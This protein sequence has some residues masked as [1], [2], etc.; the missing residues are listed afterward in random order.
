MRS[1]SSAPISVLATRP[2]T[3]AQMEQLRGVSPRIRLEHRTV[4]NPS[5]VADVMA[6]DT[7][8]LL[9]TFPPVSADAFPALR[10]FQSSS[11]GI[12]R[13]VPT[14][15]WKA[16][17]R[18]TTTSGLHAI[19]VGEYTL[20][21]MIALARDFSGFLKH[22]RRACWPQTPRPAYEQFPGRDLRGA[23][24]LIIGYGSIGRQV[25][26]LARAVGMRVL[27]IKRD[28]SVLL[29]HGYTF[30]GTGDPQGE[31]PERIVGPD[32]LLSVLPEAEFI[33]VAAPATSGTR[34]LIGV[35]EFAAMRP[36]AIF[37]NVARGELVDENAMLAALAGRRI[38]AAGLD[39]FATEPLP[40]DSP[41][42]RLEN[43]I[44]SPHVAGCSPRYDDYVF[45]I[46]AENLRRY[47]ANEPL[48]NEVDRHLGY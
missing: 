9:A 14:P 8:V 18:I 11:A 37:I 29:D 48:L 44:I 31:L 13:V 22:Q 27:A 24:V 35:R 6:S 26:R 5:L 43:V 21:M 15:L 25:A 36:D 30:S 4:A 46:F 3:K 42:W 12:D 20:G 2:L 39:V 34:H 19:T 38:A 40:A 7:E 10:W 1:D 32:Q 41:L 23:T 47:V 28:P 17:V 33:I 45:E 16:P